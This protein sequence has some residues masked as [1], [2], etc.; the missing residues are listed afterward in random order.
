VISLLALAATAV[1]QPQTVLTVDPKHRLVEGIASDGKT[2]WVSSVLDRQILACRIACRTIATLPLPLHP[3]AIAWDAERKRIW[4]AADCPPGVKAIKACDRGALIA[5]NPAGHVQT[6]IAP[7][8]GSFHPGDVSASATGVFVSDSQSGA[9]Y[10]LT[11]SGY[12]L[13]EL[14]GTSVGK[15]AQGSAVSEDGQSLL[16]AD[17]SE[18]IARIDLTNGVRTSL[19]RQDGKPLRGIDGM[20]RCGDIYYG[21][22]NGETLGAIVAISPSGSGLAVDLPLGQGSLPDPTQVTYDGKR[23]LIVA[24]SGW[25]TIEKPDFVRTAGASIVA[26]PL[27][28]DCKPQ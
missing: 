18:G 17:Y 23:L 2:I 22:Y 3:F 20:T 11:A 12:G 25:A 28:S 16:V 8:S 26:V 19:P 13:S 7:A 1:A 27:G 15:S 6:R 10:R 4:V 9:V 5:F 21:I 24:D 14:V